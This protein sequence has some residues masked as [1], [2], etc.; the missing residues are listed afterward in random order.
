MTQ[1][2]WREFVLPLP[3]L[4]GKLNHFE[5]AARFPMRAEDW[6]AL[7]KLF[8]IMRYAL[9]I[10]DTPVVVQGTDQDAG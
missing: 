3:L 2:E 1:P 8:S 5:F 9:V 7:M 6:D 10:P 4:D